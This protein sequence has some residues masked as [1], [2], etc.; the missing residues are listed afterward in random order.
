[1]KNCRTWQEF[2]YVVSKSHPINNEIQT[3]IF[4]DL[5]ADNPDNF[6]KCMGFAA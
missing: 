1:M 4:F 3:D 2:V 5:L 6:A